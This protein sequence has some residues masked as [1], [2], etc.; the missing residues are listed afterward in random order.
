MLMTMLSITTKDDMRILVRLP[1]G[2]LGRVKKTLK[3]TQTLWRN[4]QGQVVAVTPY[5]FRVAK[6]K[7]ARLESK[8]IEAEMAAGVF[9]APRGQL[10]KILY[11]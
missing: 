4:T 7:M 9:V 5:S 1:E 3:I 10:D 11:G 6:K 8:A 2:N